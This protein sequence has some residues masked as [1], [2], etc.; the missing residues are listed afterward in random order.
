MGGIEDVIRGGATGWLLEPGDDG[1]LAHAMREGDPVVLPVKPTGEIA[2]GRVAGQDAD[3]VMAAREGSYGQYCPITRSLEILGDRWTLLIVRDLNVGATSPPFANRGEQG[4][5]PIVAWRRDGQITWGIEAIMLAAGTSVQWLRDE[6]GLIASSADSAP[7]S[8][9]TMAW[10]A[11][12]SSRSGSPGVRP[13][14]A[15][16]LL[17][18]RRGEPVTLGGRTVS[19][20]RP[21][22][23]FR[24]RND[25]GGQ[26]RR[27]R[28]RCGQGFGCVQ[29]RVRSLRL[30]TDGH[31][32]PTRRRHALHPALPGVQAPAAEGR[33]GG[34]R[35]RWR[36]PVRR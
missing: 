25:A 26:T 27:R 2:V 16:T 10:T 34:G 13:A 24:R 4:T 18:D 29:R 28:G 35:Q 21:R 8:S 23:R 1:A 20:C 36:R 22:T 17:D 12:S 30:R 9:R 5:F 11:T 31:R 7:S 14:K 6:L 32:D 33:P 19:V 15:R 3:L